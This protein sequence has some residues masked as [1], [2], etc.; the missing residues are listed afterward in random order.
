MSKTAE[1]ADAVTAQSLRWLG[2]FAE[3][4]VE[5][6]QE[7][8][9]DLCREIVSLGLWQNAFLT[10]LWLVVGSIALYFANK[11]VNR[12]CRPDFGHY[13]GA[14]EICATITYLASAVPFGISLACAYSW[15]TIWA[16]PKVYLIEYFVHLYKTTK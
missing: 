9:P 5:F 10:V 11:L 3:K 16:A 15:V 2:D 1:A 6:V 4:G 14:P 13:E 7:Q 8:A 12:T